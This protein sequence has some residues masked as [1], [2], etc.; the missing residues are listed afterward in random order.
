M[1]SASCDRR[2][3]R[4]R[5]NRSVSVLLRSSASRPGPPH[6]GPGRL[7]SR[8]ADCIAALAHRPPERATRPPARP[9]RTPPP[10]GASAGS[11]LSSALYPRL[12]KICTLS[13]TAGLKPRRPDKLAGRLEAPRGMDNA[14]IHQGR[15]IRTF[16]IAAGLKPRG[17]WLAARLEA[18]RRDGK[19]TNRWDTRRLVGRTATDVVASHPAA[20]ARRGT[21]GV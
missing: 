12:G 3:R 16:T 13:I 17:Q 8:R 2:N 1:Q 4:L 18:P 5:G 11:W 19:R 6:R 9:P 20:V 15:R 14:Q 21:T 7:R 10:R